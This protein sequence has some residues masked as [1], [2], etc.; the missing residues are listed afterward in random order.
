MSK[1]SRRQFIATSSAVAAVASGVVNAKGVTYPFDS[2][3]T[4]AALAPDLDRFAPP[5]KPLTRLLSIFAHISPDV[6]AEF[7]KV[8]WEF[9][10]D[11]E[12][13]NVALSD[14][15]SFLMDSDIVMAINTDGIPPGTQLFYRFTCENCYLNRTADSLD[16]ELLQVLEATESRVRNYNRS[17]DIAIDEQ[18]LSIFRKQTVVQDKSAYA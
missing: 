5:V 10:T 15:S 11:A 8:S 6:H 14:R 18:F 7:A 12:F 9:A 2:V 4:E 13:K 1:L 3:T 17:L 16:A